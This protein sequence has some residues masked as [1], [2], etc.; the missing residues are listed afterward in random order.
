M[1]ASNS[2][3]QTQLIDQIKL[4]DSIPIQL[5]LMIPILVLM[6][7]FGSLLPGNQKM[8]DSKSHIKMPETQKTNS[9]TTVE[10]PHPKSNRLVF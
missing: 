1:D 3:I 4:V 8:S 10:N 6:M 2:L 5:F 7:D 9:I